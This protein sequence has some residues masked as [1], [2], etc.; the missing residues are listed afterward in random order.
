MKYKIRKIDEVL[1]RYAVT[2]EAGNILA[3]RMTL[4]AAKLAMHFIK[5][6]K[7]AGI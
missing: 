6:G 5:S 4:K 2:D 3:K 1:N 7:G